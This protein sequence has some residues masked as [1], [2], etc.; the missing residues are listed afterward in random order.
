[1]ALNFCIRCSRLAE[2]FQ[3]V[4]NPVCFGLSDNTKGA[5]LVCGRYCLPPGHVLVAFSKLTLQ[6]ASVYRCGD[7]AIMAHS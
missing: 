4:Q 5:V 7:L 2:V 3:P 6:L 1:M